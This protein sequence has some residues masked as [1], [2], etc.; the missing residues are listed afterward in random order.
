[1]VEEILGQVRDNHAS[2]GARAKPINTPRGAAP[3]KDS[4]ARSPHHLP[5]PRRFSISSTKNTQAYSSAL[6]VP[7]ALPDTRYNIKY[8][9]TVPLREKILS[10]QA[11]EPVPVYAQLLAYDAMVA[12]VYD[13]ACLASMT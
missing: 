13:I 8:R 2:R 11:A 10:C 7:R 6:I 9:A 4:R 3:S 12:I 5:R 1:M